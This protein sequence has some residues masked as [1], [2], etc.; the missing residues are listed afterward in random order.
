MHRI[1]ILLL[2]CFPV[3]AR[4]YQT[5]VTPLPGETLAG[6]CRFEMSL[7]AANETVHGV[8]VVFDRGRDIMKFYSDPDVTAFARQHNF[9]LLMAHQCPAKNAPGGPEE[10]DMDPSHGVGRAIL[11]A[12]SQFA[13]QS[14]HP[15]I[16]SAKLTLLGFSGTG[17]LFA[18]FVGWA[19]NRVLASIIANPGHYDPVGMD[20]VQLPESA[21]GAPELVIAGGADKVSGTQRPYDYF[22][23]YQ[24]RGAPWAFIVQNRT[25]HCCVINVKSLILSWLE[26]IL[27]LRKPSPA[28][29]L[30]AIDHSVGWL[31]FI[32]T[33]PAEVKDTWGNS[34]WNVCDASLQRVG[35]TAPLGQV[36]A[37][38]FPS[39]HVARAWL[40]FVKEAQHPVTSLP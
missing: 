21:L 39:Y 5:T 29:P 11:T 14:G 36:P 27:R 31:G 19:P 38:W 16:A 8:F 17:A 20:K 3:L 4:T 22:S 6:P 34:T 24:Q 25:P 23:S 1:L 33:C 37:G 2:F 7:P 26:E 9:G 30:A 28:K 35:R 13:K 32:R 12:L 18:H 15:E 10:M 40:T